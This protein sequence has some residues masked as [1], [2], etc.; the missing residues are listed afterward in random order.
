MEMEIVRM[1]RARVR[2]ALSLSLWEMMKT[3]DN[4]YTRMIDDDRQ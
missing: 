3:I 1:G 4:I 2:H